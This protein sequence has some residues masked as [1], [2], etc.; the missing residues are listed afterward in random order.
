MPN[1]AGQRA[2]AGSTNTIAV[3]ILR[4]QIGLLPIRMIRRI[5][6]RHYGSKVAVGRASKPTS[7]LAAKEDSVSRHAMY[8]YLEGA[9]ISHAIH[10]AAHGVAEALLEKEAAK[11]RERAHRRAERQI[12]LEKIT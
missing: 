7:K 12:K 1:A 3:P 5:L 2:K 11:K 10:L 8:Q 9:T 6:N 4:G